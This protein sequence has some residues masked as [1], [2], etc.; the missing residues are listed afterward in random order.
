MTASSEFI[1]L[2]WIGDHYEKWWTIDALT[3]TIAAR[4]A[5]FTFEQRAQTEEICKE[6]PDRKEKISLPLFQ[7]VNEY[8]E[9]EHV[10]IVGSPGIGK[11]TTLLRLL[12]DFARQELEKPIPRIPV[13]IQLKRY[14]QSAHGSE[15]RSGMLALIQ[16]ALEPKLSLEIS[17][18]KKLLFQKERLILLLDGLNEMPAGTALTELKAFRDKCDQAKIPLIC[19]TRETG[20]TLGIKRRL[21][22]QPL[23]PQGEIQRFLDKCMP[24]KKQEVLQLLDRDNRELSRTPFVLWMLYDSFRQTG[25]VAKT[26]GEAFQQFFKSFKECREDAPVPEERRR[27]WDSW[28]EHLAFSMLNSPDPLNPGLVIFEEQAEIILTEKFGTESPSRIN[29]LMKHHLVQEVSHQEIGFHH[30]LIQEYYAAEALLLKLNPRYSEALT[31]EQ[32]KQNYLNYLKWTEPIA[33]MLGLADEGLAIRVVELAIGVDLMLGARLAGEVKREYQERSVEIIIGIKIPDWLRIKLLGETRSLE[34]STYFLKILK[35]PDPDVRSRAI[36]ASREIGAENALPLIQIAIEDSDSRVRQCAIRVIG[37][38]RI[39]QAIPLL[40]KIMLQ[41]EETEVREIAV[42][43]A[44]GRLSSEEA[45]LEL[46]RAMQVTDGNISTMASHFLEEEMTHDVVIPILFKA[47]NNIDLFICRS[48]AKLLGKLGNEKAIPAL[49]EVYELALDLDLAVEA[50]W[51]ASEIKRRLSKAQDNLTQPQAE[52]HKAEVDMW[53]EF[54]K[55]E[56]HHRRGNAIYH[57][58][59]YLDPKAAISLSVK[60]L[61]E[62]ESPYV[63]G[64]AI[65]SLARLSGK[66]QIPLLIQALNDPDHGVRKHASQA[67]MTMKTNASTDLAIPKETVTTLIQAF[68]ESQDISSR[69]QTIDTL[70]DIC[71]LQSSALLHEGMEDAFLEASASLS[72]SSDPIEK[73]LGYL[74]RSSAARS[75]RQFSSERACTRLLEMIEDLDIVI[76]MRAAESLGQTSHQVSSKF[77]PKLVKLIYSPAAVGG[78]ALQAIASIQS[79][80]QFYN[81]EIFQAA[82]TTEAT[83]QNAEDLIHDKLNAIAQGVQKMS[84]APK[85]SF[86]N[87]Q[88]VQIIE[89]IETYNENNY[90]TDPEA[91]QALEDLQQTIANL[92]RQYPQASET[93]A[94]TIIDAEF[95]TIQTTQPKRWQNFLKLKRLWNGVK[96]G[97][98]KMGEHY[99]EETAWGK[100]FIGL[101]EGITDEVE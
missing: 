61:L 91:Q 87:A 49:L 16:D 10:L 77:L 5:T 40:K 39:E 92:Q 29:E 41:E 90:T 72:G 83:T 4:Q 37:E 84:D 30:Q 56:E 32:L 73:N 80:C 28:L 59:S 11:S 43:C 45:I 46:L 2:N 93:E 35:N 27:Q 9:K 67:L 65:N 82:Q 74:L 26:M 62:D 58:T 64:H 85:Y 99:A 51:S 13:L 75:L 21:E 101:L 63:R 100:G 1:Y 55:S 8:A 79:R 98:L 19:T 42:I 7:G 24:S 96:K 94:A 68:N 66:E 78:N 81:Y 3:E 36:W 48:A 31:D 47:L 70:T 89:Q 14:K 6:D 95:T 12:V 17:E 25:D 50:G 22:I 69:R 15:D 86:P 20:N 97:S 33:L 34:V 71:S 60:A 76:A 88:K 18:V 57:L 44:L 38:L 53:R 54:L 52:P 23:T